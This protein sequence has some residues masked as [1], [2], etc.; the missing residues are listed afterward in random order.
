ME[1]LEQRCLEQLNKILSKFDLKIDIFNL[2]PLNVLQYRLID[3]RTFQNGYYYS[4]CFWSSMSN[5]LIHSKR[6]NSIFDCLKTFSYRRYSEA[7]NAI[8]QLENISCLEE[9]VIKMDLMGV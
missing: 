9:L 8:K 1:N 4:L 7:Y 3:N 6:N 2:A 5:I